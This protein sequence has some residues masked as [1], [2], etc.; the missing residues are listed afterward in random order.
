MQLFFGRVFVA[1]ALVLSAG[2]CGRDLAP[3]PDRPGTL[4]LVTDPSRAPAWTVPYGAEFWRRA[5]DDDA[6]AVDIG[7]AVERVSHAIART[8]DGAPRIVARRYAASFDGHGLRLSPT[9]GA[10]ELQL[11][12]TRIAAGDR[13]LYDGARG[14]AWS[15]LG[16]TA[17]ADLGPGLVEHYESRSDG[18]ELSWIVRDRAALAG[19][20]LVVD[21]AVAGLTFA[22]ADARGLQ[23][24]DRAGT[25]RVRIAAAELVDARGQRWPVAAEA[26][27]TTVRWRVPAATLQDATFPIAL[28]PVIGPEVELTAPV[29]SSGE[30][31]QITPALAS[32]GNGYLVVW[33]DWMYGYA[34]HGTRLSA[35]GAVLDPDGLVIGVA[36]DLESHQQPSI[37]SNGTDYFV[38]WEGHHDAR[39][40]LYGTRVTAAGAVLDASPLALA[41]GD[42]DKYDPTVASNGTDY[43]I[44]WSGPTG[45]VGNDW[46]ALGNRVTAAGAV[47]DG[48]GFALC[49]GT[50]FQGIP[51]AAWNGTNYL[52]AWGDSRDGVYG[53]RVTS[54]GALLD[55]SGFAI[56]TGGDFDAPVIASR[57]GDSLVVW[58]EFASGSGWDIHGGRVTAAGA[59]LDGDGFVIAGGADPQLDPVVASNGTDYFVGWDTSPGG[60]HGNVYGRRVTAA[61]A[62]LDGSG[63]TITDA[64]GTQ[65]W[66][67]IA[68]NGTDY[69]VAWQDFR[70]GGDDIYGA[71]VTAAGAVTTGDGVIVNT[72]PDVQHE[73]WVASN[74]TGY[75][76]VWVDLRSGTGYDI[77]GTRLS[78]SGAVLDPSGLALATGTDA[79]F[80]PSVASNGTDYFVVWADNRD[81]KWDIYGRRVTSSGAVLDGNGIAV[82]L[83]IP[84]DH[85]PHDNPSVASNGSGYFVV[86]EQTNPNGSHGVYG[87]RVSNAGAILDAAGVQVSS[88]AALADVASNGT[89]YLVAWF[90]CGSDTCPIRVGRVSAAGTVLDPGGVVLG[91]GTSYYQRARLVA[92]NGT[93]YLLA[94]AR[95]NGALQ[96]DIYTGR[97]TAAGA[98]QDPGGQLL[99]SAAG[100][101]TYPAVASDGSG[102]F[103]VWQDGRNGANTDIYGTEVSA[104]GDAVGAELAISATT[105]IEDRPNLAFN[106]SSGGYLVAYD[107]AKRIRV[108]LLGGAVDPPDVDAGVPIDAGPL[109]DAG[110]PTDAAAV[111]ADDAGLTIDAGVATGDAAASIDAP[112]TTPTPDSGGCS[113]S[114]GPSALAGLSLLALLLR[115]R[116]RGDAST[117]GFRSR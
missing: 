71:H 81:Y 94:W 15:I 27:A 110:V 26:T 95:E 33:S 48:N 31:H 59:R 45:D 69:V 29:A 98:V 10:S 49:T 55:G 30:G 70:G 79:Q 88:S 38:A 91:N 114:T 73:P 6:A 46:K 92:S 64:P 68:S 67:A 1:A 103:V 25:S 57:G 24:A 61:G 14:A 72:A 112:S 36:D 109:T 22:G 34:I 107:S 42:H 85:N 35:S 89:D 87:S 3:P 78:A 58:R 56:A 8:G 108:R 80:Q 2:G 96:Q 75:L 16:N 93:D 74:G 37:A 77:Y 5:A 66:P 40:D 84:N 111:P 65:R 9:D 62:L 82:S 23:L 63:V 100:N 17:Q 53:G 102:Y 32:N 7:D 11:R 28:D 76:V 115:R 12:T 99:A 41:T 116:A 104:T 90:T 43:L 83:A 54:S 50:S 86:W 39:Q 106:A 47:L 18:V 105:R 117:A 60:G 113:T 21:V 51:G 19:D 101:Q 44:V 13:T 20:D 52:V 4:Q 97:V